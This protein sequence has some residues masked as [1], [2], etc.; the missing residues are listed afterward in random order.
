MVLCALAPLLPPAHAE[1]ARSILPER[2]HVA[3]EPVLDSE[4]LEFWPRFRVAVESGSREALLPMV[5]FPLVV[6]GQCLYEERFSVRQVFAPEEIAALA[7]STELVRAELSEGTLYAANV[8]Y[9][10]AGEGAEQRFEFARTAAG[11]QLV[12]AGLLKA[13]CPPRDPGAAPAIAEPAPPPP[14]LP[15]AAQPPA[16]APAEDREPT[17]FERWFRSNRESILFLGFALYT[18][19]TYLAA[20]RAFGRAP[21]LRRLAL[22][23]V[24]VA[25]VAAAVVGLYLPTRAPPTM[26]EG[27]FRAMLYMAA[28]AIVFAV[29][30]VLLALVVP[31]GRSGDEREWVSQSGDASGDQRRC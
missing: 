7:E 11:F 14:A 6:H 21:V 31:R 4:F 2:R 29:L 26:W 22:G 17:M 9:R 23:L 8:R 12:R 24:G 3:I 30:P 25:L 16:P 13:D 28:A 27:F 15:G 10:D 18:V 20:R 19:L 5:V 1:D